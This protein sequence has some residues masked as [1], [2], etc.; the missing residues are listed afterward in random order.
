MSGERE[1][2]LAGFLDAEHAL[3]DD[4]LRYWDSRSR[5]RVLELGCAT[6]RLLSYLRRAAVQVVGL[7][8]SPSLLDR[9]RRN[10]PGVPVFR[11]D[12]RRFAA[13]RISCVFSIHAAFQELLTRDDR[14]RCLACV[15]EALNPDGQLVLDLQAASPRAKGTSP[16][17]LAAE[18]ACEG[19]RVARFETAQRADGQIAIRS[20]YFEEGRP[21]AETTRR[22]ALLD[23]RTLEEE[24]RAAGFELF[25]I[26]G[27]WRESRFQERGPGMVV[28]AARV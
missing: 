5:G 20:E 12:L 7:E 27:D 11:A 21:V 24:L 2:L 4:T 8:P 9:A 15:R 3:Q 22:L 16:R 10:A 18:M 6:G 17:R 19:K 14:A 26:F 25:A 1:A 28:E 23:R 13:R